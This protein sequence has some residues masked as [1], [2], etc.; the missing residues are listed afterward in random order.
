MTMSDRPLR[1]GLIGTGAIAQ[2]YVQ[3]FRALPEAEIV[4]VADVRADAARATAENVGCPAFDSHES[5]ARGADLDAVLVC[6]PPSTHPEICR[7][8]LEAGVPVLC[9]KP[10][11]T[12]VASARALVDLAK[13]SGVLFTMATKFRFVDDIVRAKSIV[14]SGLLGDPILFE[15]A[16]TSRVEMT[17]RWNSDPKR[18]GGGVIIDNGTHSVD[19]MRYFLGP[20]EEVFAVEG[21]RLQCVEVEDTARIF[22]RTVNGILG[23][24]DL[25]WSINKQLDSYVDLYGSHGVIRIGWRESKYRQISSTDWVVFGKG[26]DKIEAMG[27]VIRNFVR[28]LRGEERILVTC[29]DAMAS[30]EV[31]EAVY[32]SLETDVW[33]RVRDEGTTE[34]RGAVR[35]AAGA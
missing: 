34:R 31:I 6:T 35:E 9:E 22:A 29:D 8:F 10:L 13:R 7:W 21:K 19:V 3:V 16:F 18:S 32:R 33:T 25:S 2:S 27:G 28:S 20:I 17:G 5:L 1:F 11:C 14:A 26:Y 4:A 24:I 30:V 12:D 23:S 15:N